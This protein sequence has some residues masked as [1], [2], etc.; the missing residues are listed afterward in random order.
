MPDLSSCPM[1]L[2]CRPGSELALHQNSDTR[3]MFPYVYVSVCSSTE[4][5]FSRVY[6]MY[7]AMFSS[8]F[9]RSFIHSLAGQSAT[10]V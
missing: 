5:F 6:N 9:V 1:L 8:L 4:T 7:T 3:P 10:S 2:H